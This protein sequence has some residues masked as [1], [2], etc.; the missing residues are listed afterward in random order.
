[1][2]PIY[3]SDA[4]LAQS[5][6]PGRNLRPYHLRDDRPGPK[7]PSPSYDH[8]AV[9]SPPRIGDYGRRA[10]PGPA[11]DPLIFQPQDAP[12]TPA[13][14]IKDLHIKGFRSLADVHITDM[15]RAA[16]MIGAN[17]SGKS[18]LIKFFTM[19]SWMLRSGKLG[20]FVQLNGGASDQLFGGSRTTRHMEARIAIR[21]EKGLNEYEFKLAYGHP[22][23]FVF[24]DERFRFT[25]GDGLGQPSWQH[26]GSG[27]GE[28]EIRA[29]RAER[30]AE[31]LG[32][33]HQTATAV[34]ALLCDMASY[35]FHD[36]SYDSWFM[37][38]WHTA[39]Y[40]QLRG[41]GGNLAAVLYRLEQNDPDRYGAI[42]EHIKRILPVFDGFALEERYGKVILRWYHTQHEQII[43]AHLTSDGSLRFFALV[44]LL[45]LPSKML[46]N[47]LLLDEPELGLHPM[48]IELVGGMIRSLAVERQV[49]VATQSPLLVNVFDLDDVFVLDLKKGKTVITRHNQVD[50]KHWLDE[51]SLGQLWQKNLLGGRP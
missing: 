34:T 36:T 8:D 18:N 48:A 25:H 11:A 1:M 6:P 39:E 37:K 17:G 16:V 51:Y 27:H 23:R 26:L 2:I 24:T 32:V 21:A 42:C 10:G 31:Q 38:N 47:V 41:H 46:P 33:N 30:R 13:T 14:Q 40:S 49:L 45:N 15:P 5:G 35:Q 7:A 28:A 20:N 29:A 9:A 19:V 12:V 43:G 4:V 22:D 3:G 50:Y 44:T